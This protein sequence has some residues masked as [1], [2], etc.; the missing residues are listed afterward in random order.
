MGPAGRG[1]AGEGFETNIN[2][3][4]ESTNLCASSTGSS[5]R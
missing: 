3:V 1:L 2:G 5:I 4:T